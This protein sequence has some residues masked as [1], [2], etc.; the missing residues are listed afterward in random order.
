MIPREIGKWS[1]RLRAKTTGSIRNPV[2]K[3]KIGMNSELPT[4]FEL[5]RGRLLV[6]RGV[7]SE[8]GQERADYARQVDSL[9]QQRGGGEYREQHDEIDTFIGFQPAQH[10]RTSATKAEQDERHEHDDLDH[11]IPACAARTHQ[12]DQGRAGR[13]ARTR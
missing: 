13:A 12:R 8:T 9:R 6:N 5:G 10:V 1:I 4:T 7:D 11:R 2:T 3:K